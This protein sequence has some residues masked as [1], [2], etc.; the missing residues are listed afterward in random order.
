MIVLRKFATQ[1]GFRAIEIR[2]RKTARVFIESQDMRR[3][4]ANLLMPIR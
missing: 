3:K 4:K 1:K 2:A